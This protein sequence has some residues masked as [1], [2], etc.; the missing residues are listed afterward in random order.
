MSRRDDLF[1]NA[2]LA[3]INESTK[4]IVNNWPITIQ[5]IVGSSLFEDNQPLKV[6]KTQIHKI[7]LFS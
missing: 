1:L 7:G 6:S 3:P 2:F 5:S 4:T